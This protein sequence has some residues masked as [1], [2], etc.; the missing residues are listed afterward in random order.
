MYNASAIKN[1][2]PTSSLV[3]FENKK[4]FLQRKTR[5]STT[6]LALLL[7]LYWLLHSK[8]CFYGF[9]TFQ[10]DGSAQKVLHELA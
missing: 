10:Y 4:K 9:T 5:K 2:K 7:L 8:V 1:Y 6:T 3:R